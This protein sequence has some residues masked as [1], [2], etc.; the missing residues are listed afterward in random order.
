LYWKCKWEWHNG[1]VVKLCDWGCGWNI[2][3]SFWFLLWGKLWPLP[4]KLLLVEVGLHTWFGG[5]E[6]MWW[7]DK[8]QY[9]IQ[10]VLTFD[11]TKPE[12]CMC[13]DR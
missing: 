10:L 7:K 11:L 3:A 2:Y 13:P 8:K 5:F 9:N 12:V 4:I 1:G 6:G